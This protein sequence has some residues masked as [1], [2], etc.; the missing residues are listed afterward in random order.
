VTRIVV[1]TRNPGK[2]VEL[3]RLLALASIALAPIGTIDPSMP[4][5]VEDADSFEDNAIKKAREVA[6]HT[7]S[8]S[9][10]DDSGLEVDALDGAP[11]IHSAR[12]SGLGARANVE[13]LL[14]ALD[15]VDDTRRSARFRCVLALVDP[16]DVDHP[17]LVRGSCEG[18]IGRTPRGEHGFGYDPIFVPRG[19]TRTMAELEDREKDAISHRGVACRALADVLEAWLRTR[20]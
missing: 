15:G 11:G 19:E 2:V 9:L 7:R 3:E 17:L 14:R 4:D 18:A 20:T 5:V 8:I 10:G 16:R 6:L 12:F 13:K 1:A